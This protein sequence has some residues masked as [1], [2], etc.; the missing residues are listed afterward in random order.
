[1]D[2]S[3]N[4]REFKFVLEPGL[5]PVLR[6]RV[7][8]QLEVDDHA[9]DGYP[10]LSEYFDSSDRL[11]YWQKQFGTPNRRRVRGRLYGRTD[12]TI[13]P[14]AFIEVKHKLDGVTVKRRVPCGVEHLPVFSSG[15]I[16]KELGDSVS[17]MTA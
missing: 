4:R 8:R 5:V 1:M 15:S 14:S 9:Q 13:P 7:A 6:G 3:Q 12:G 11:T 17:T 10:V 2:A 16:P